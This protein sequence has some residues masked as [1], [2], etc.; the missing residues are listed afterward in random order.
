MSLTAS[1][2]GIVAAVTA[3]LN[4]APQ[5]GEVKIF[6]D[7][8]VGCDNGG[9]CQAVSLLPE[10]GEVGGNGWGGPITMFRTGDK[11]DILKIRVSVEMNDIDRYRMIV[12]GMLVDTGPVNMGDDPIEIV[13]QDAR[14]VANAI[15]RGNDLIILGPQGGKLTHISLAG[16]AAALRYMDSRQ[17]RTGT[18]TALVA[19]GRRDFTALETNVPVISTDQWK[20]SK[21]IPETAEIVSLVEGSDCKG[22]RFGV[23]EDQV[24]PLGQRGEKI[25]A[26]VLVSCGSGAYNFSSAAYIGEIDK[27]DD[28]A[29]WNFKPAKFDFNPGWNEENKTVLLVNGYW[30]E[31]DQILGSYAKG[32][33][34]GDCGNSQ[35]Y[36]WDGEQFRLI[37][38]SSMEECRGVLEWITIWRAR[39]E[40]L[41]QDTASK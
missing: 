37:E 33:G 1:F 13:G 7:W 23:V 32:R 27:A 40:K 35:S 31:K 8:A 29:Q 25:R 17:K 18:R 34:P 14:K 28:A 39:F 16:S 6:K 4:G 11:Q 30:D 15:I 9:V 36:V 10:T 21:T 12:D 24:F 3:A 20:I 22:E 26:L 5:L 2:F 38:A 19:K 41:E